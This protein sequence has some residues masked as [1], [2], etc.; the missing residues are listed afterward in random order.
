MKPFYQQKHDIPVTLK[1]RKK[2]LELFCSDDQTKHGKEVKG[3]NAY[4]K[5][6]TPSQPVERPFMFSVRPTYLTEAL[7]RC[8]REMEFDANKKAVQFSRDN[9]KHLISVG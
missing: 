2:R 6:F 7:E 8:G 1:F 3:A 4:K 5:V 9:F